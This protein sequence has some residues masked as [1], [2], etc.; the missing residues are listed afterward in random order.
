MPSP[1]DLATT[2]A[3]VLATTPAMTTRQGELLLI[4]GIGAQR[5]ALPV[6]AVARV[7]PMAAPTPLPAAPP[8]VVG[9]IPFR[10]ALLPVVDPR[11]RLGQPTVAQQ[12]DQHLVAVAAEPRYLLWVDRAET[13]VAAP[14][15]ALAE[16][17]GDGSD[18]LAPQLVLLGDDYLPVLSVAALAPAPLHFTID[19]ATGTRLR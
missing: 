12:P 8:G 5:Y 11:P 14:P 16:L 6:A 3:T 1:A 18:P 4:V 2:Q 13:V 10:G 17:P 19:A 15:L 7:L 9:V